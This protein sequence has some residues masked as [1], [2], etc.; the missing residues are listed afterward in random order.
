MEF[1]ALIIGGEEKQTPLP[2]TMGTPDVGGVDITKIMK[3][4]KCF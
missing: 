3:A 2:G 1:L 4:Y